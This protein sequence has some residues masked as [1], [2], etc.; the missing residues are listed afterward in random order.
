MEAK[1]SHKKPKYTKD[2]QKNSK[3]ASEKTTTTFSAKD[4]D[5]RIA[6]R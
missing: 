5:D 2:Y 4:S 1:K 6:K 3:R